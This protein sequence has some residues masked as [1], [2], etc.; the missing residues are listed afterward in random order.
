MNTDDQQPTTPQGGEQGDDR[1]E[2][3]W[4]APGHR[5]SGAALPPPGPSAQQHPAQQHPAQQHPYAPQPQPAP[6]P[7]QPNAAGPYAVAP[8]QLPPPPRDQFLGT[9]AGSPPRRPR[10][11]RWAPLAGTA[12]AAAVLAS[13]ATAGLLGGFTPS[14]TPRDVSIATL[15]TQ[16]SSAVP[17]SSTAQDPDWEA[18]ANAVR[19]SVV[20][21]QV[22]LANGSAEGSGVIIDSD[23]YVLSNNHVVGDAVDGGIQVTLADGRVYDATI[24]GTDPTTDLAVIALTDPP[25][26]LQPAVL[27]DSD[28]VEVGSPVMAVGNP[29]GLSS[30]AT[31]GIV[32]ALDRPVTTSDG[33]ATVVTNAIQI[34]AAINPGNSGGPLFD[35][36]GRVIGITSS[37]ASL[38]SGSSSSSGSIGLGFAIPS[39]LADRVAAELI[40]GGS[41]SHAFLGVSLSDG[42]ATADGTTRRGAVIEEVSDGTPASA[43]DL[44]AGD[45]VVAIDDNPVN[46]AE[47]L[48][49]HVRERPSGAAAT[50]T[51][52]RDGKAFSVDVTFATLDQ[53][54]SSSMQQDDGSSQQLPGLPWGQGG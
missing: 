3:P 7:P 41:A 14:A 50:L 43:A 32:S 53:A 52:V 2:Q 6:Y 54:S 45:V 26:D 23:G 22:Q 11:G 38:S 16:D 27:A 13:V 25:D 47:S 31:T 1:P 51:V 49:A 4:H 18:V 37:I 35:A 29:L 24:V 28:P 19:A 21:I 30:T 8:G 12:A 36:S 9:V 40:Q 39:N 42:T 20:A 17:V 15:G 44:R 34:D 46:G 48:T 5:W 10:S 33:S